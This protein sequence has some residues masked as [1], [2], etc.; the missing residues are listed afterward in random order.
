MT[1]LEQK[2]TR[3]YRELSAHYERERTQHAEQ[4]AALQRQVEHF[5]GQVTRLIADY[6]RLAETLRGLWS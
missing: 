3:A 2:L 6:R 5:A 4:I 1:A